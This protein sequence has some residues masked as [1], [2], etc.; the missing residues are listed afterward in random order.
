[1]DKANITINRVCE[2]SSVYE[3]LIENRGRT[4][5]RRRNFWF[6]TPF[7]V[8]NRQTTNIDQWK[9]AYNVWTV[10]I[11]FETYVEDL[12]KTVGIL[13]TADVTSGLWRPWTRHMTA[14]MEKRVT[15]GE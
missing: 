14:Q 5:E 2:T 10:H 1:M 12:K 8:R 15:I 9:Y 4:I 3:T 13:S 7:S 11:R 6:K